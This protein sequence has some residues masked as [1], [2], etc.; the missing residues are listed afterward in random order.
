MRV[1]RLSGWIAAAAAI[2]VAYGLLVIP[3]LPAL[4]AGSAGQIPTAA[5]LIGGLAAL[6]VAAG[7]GLLRRSGWARLV[8][9]A[10]SS[11]ALV[12]MYAPATAVAVANG[13]WPGIQLA[14][15]V[16]YLV[17]LFAILRRWPTE[18]AGAG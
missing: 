8:A 2:L 3:D 12:F 11:F 16:G 17:V 14:G 5:I 18:P 6:H 1:S 4:A 13:V 7:I 9:G 10:V 15:I